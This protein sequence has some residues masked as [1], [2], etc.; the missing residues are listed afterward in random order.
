MIDMLE[1]GALYPPVDFCADARAAYDAISAPDPCELAGSSPKLHLISV[2][3][4]MAYGLVRKLFWVDTRDMLAD[5]LTKAWVDRLLLRS[6]SND[7]KYA[8]KHE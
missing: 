6:C 2:R 4:G 8:F 1:G 5:G 7:C 3:D